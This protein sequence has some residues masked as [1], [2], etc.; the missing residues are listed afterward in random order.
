MARLLGFALLLF[1]AGGWGTAMIWA[2]NHGRN[3]FRFKFRELP[4]WIRVYAN[5]AAG[6]VLIAIATGSIYAAVQFISLT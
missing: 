5:V 3:P 4:F 2:A 1:I 6:A